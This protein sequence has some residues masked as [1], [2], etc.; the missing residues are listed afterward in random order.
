MT[1]LSSF[2]VSLC[3]AAILFSLLMFLVPEEGAGRAVRVAASAFLLVVILRS[4]GS[5][6]DGLEEIDLTTEDSPVPL[7]DEVV[8]QQAEEALAQ[9]AAQHLDAAGCV[10]KSLSA[11]V[12]YGQEGFTGVELLVEVPDAG[13][14]ETAL[15]ALSDLAIPVTVR[16]KGEDNG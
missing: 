7:A 14:K 10:Y 9:V 15:L 6:F 5:L 1:A 2:I 8:E 3:G 12:T 13:E 16:V 11:Q 4:A